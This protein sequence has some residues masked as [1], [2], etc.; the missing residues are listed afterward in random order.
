LSTQAKTEIATVWRAKKFFGIFIETENFYIFSFSFFFSF[1]HFSFIRFKVL[2]TAC[3]AAEKPTSTTGPMSF[4]FYG[5]IP[6][7][8]LSPNSFPTIVS[9]YLTQAD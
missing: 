4:K 8:T 1:F 3:V 2:T 9:T 7:P 5:S 6:I